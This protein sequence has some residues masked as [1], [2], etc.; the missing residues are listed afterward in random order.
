MLTENKDP[1]ERLHLLEALMPFMGLIF[2]YFKLRYKVNSP[3]ESNQAFL[4]FA[5]LLQIIYLFII[6]MAFL[7]AKSIF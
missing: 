4:L 3:I 5:N 6:L 7:G 1:R 2:L